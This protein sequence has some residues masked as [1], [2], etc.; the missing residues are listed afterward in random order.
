MGKQSLAEKAAVVDEV[1]SILDSSQM[2]LAIE[3]TGMTV[4]D[5]NTLRN[6]LRE[7]DAVCMVVKNTLMKRAIA[8]RPTWSGLDGFL[9]GQNAFILVRGDIGKA[10]KA[11][12]D[13][14]KKAKKTEF[15]GAAIDGLALDLEQAK[16]IADLPPKE[17]L[18]AQVAG[19]LNSMAS[20]VAGGLNALPTQVV[21]GVNEIPSTL[22]RAIRAVADK[23]QD[24]A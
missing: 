1:Q 6:E 21:T 17:V 23:D 3:Y 10:V 12:Q 20:R 15:R 13:F 2:V 8:D 5:F 24:A 18:M 19:S 4:P 22:V 14:Q 11:Y 16:A 7:S 9:A